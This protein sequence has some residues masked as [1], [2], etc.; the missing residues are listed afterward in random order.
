MKETLK[1]LDELPWIVK[2]L[3]TICATVYGNIVRLVRSLA[4]ENIVGV[5]LAV[6]L[7]CTAGAGILWIWDIIR[8]ATKKDIWWID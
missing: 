2:L 6:I 5:I 8:V 7:L 4:K 1:A 3:L